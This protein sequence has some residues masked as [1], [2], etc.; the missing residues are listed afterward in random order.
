M[1]LT[2]LIVFT[3]VRV[4]VNKDKAIMYKLLFQRLFVLVSE[5]IQKPIKWKH[6]DS[7]G[8]KV[9]T[10]NICLKQMSS[11]TSFK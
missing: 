6:I 9:I 10:V 1:F 3:L 7:V 11:K 2:I 5:L 8:F 4:F